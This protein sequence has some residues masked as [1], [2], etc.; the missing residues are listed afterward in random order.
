MILNEK[1]INKFVSFFKN[2]DCKNVTLIEKQDIYYYIGQKK[3]FYNDLF[4][5]NLINKHGIFIS[6]FVH[7]NTLEN[8]YLVRNFETKMYFR[9]T[10]MINSN[11]QI[12]QIYKDYSNS[13]SL[14]GLTIIEENMDTK[15]RQLLNY[16]EKSNPDVRYFFLEVLTYP[17][18]NIWKM[19][20]GLF[21]AIDSEKQM[22]KEI[23]PFICDINF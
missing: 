2:N 5:I 1:S 19:K 17:N 20:N 4:L 23:L 15:M 7:L 6:T 21:I 13:H 12:D 8:I 18:L 3:E 10:Y 11:K 9:S 14:D 16:Y 22:L